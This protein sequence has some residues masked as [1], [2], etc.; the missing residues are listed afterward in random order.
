VLMVMRIHRLARSIGDLQDIV[1]TLKAKGG[2][3]QGLRTADRYL[4]RDRKC[5]LDMVGVLAEFET[6]LRHERQLEGIA[7]AKA[8]GV[9]QGRPASID[10]AKVREMKAQAMGAA[11][12]PRL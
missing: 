12:M 5:L 3:A 1:R 4:D 10:A 11:A 8:E 2:V 6:N 9:Y 7:K